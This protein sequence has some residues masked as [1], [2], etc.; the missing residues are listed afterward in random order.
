MNTRLS[1]RILIAASLTACV[2]AG[3]G[4]VVDDTLPAALRAGPHEV[5]LNGAR[6]FYR[7]G[8]TARPGVPPVVFLHGGPGQGSQHFDALAGPYLEPQLRMVYYDQRGSGKSERP[9][10]GAATRA[11]SV[12]SSERSSAPGDSY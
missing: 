7:V 4:I 1:V 3:G 12:R 5:T 11:S 9:A 6:Q 2:R 10:S 8:G